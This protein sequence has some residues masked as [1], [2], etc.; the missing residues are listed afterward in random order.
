MKFFLGKDEEDGD[1]SDD[2]D[3]ELPTIKTIALANRVNKKTKKREKL[4]L[5][6]VDRYVVEGTDGVVTS[7]ENLGDVLGFNCE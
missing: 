2:N 5:A 7:P 6:D 3:E 1:E 4:I